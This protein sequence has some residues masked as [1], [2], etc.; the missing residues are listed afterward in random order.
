MLEPLT[1]DD[2]VVVSSWMSDPMDHVKI[3]GNAFAYPLS[4]E[5]YRSYFIDSAGNAQ[6]RLCFKYSADGQPAGMASFTRIDRKNDYGHIGLVAIAPSLR[7]AGLGSALLRE[8]LCLGFDRLAFNRI[9]LVVIESNTMAYEFYTEKIG[10]RDEGLIRDIIKVGDGYLSWHSLSM[11][12]NEWQQRADR[13]D[14]GDFWQRAGSRAVGRK[15]TNSA[16]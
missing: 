15:E 2:F 13:T 12:K 11:L 10:F 1:E 7:G 14:A 4:R 3:C 8:L 16:T 5:Q 9:D 6:R